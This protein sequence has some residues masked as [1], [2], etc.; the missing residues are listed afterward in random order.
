MAAALATALTAALAVTLGVSAEAGVTPASAASRSATGPSRS[1]T[2]PRN[3]FS[4]TG[5]A[6]SDVS[7]TVQAGA[8]GT[9]EGAADLMLTL[10]PGALHDGV[11]M[12]A[13]PRDPCLTVC[14]QPGFICLAD[15]AFTAPVPPARCAG[16]G[17]ERLAMKGPAGDID[18]VGSFGGLSRG[19]VA[20]LRHGKLFVQFGVEVQQC[21][22]NGCSGATPG[23]AGWRCGSAPGCS[24]YFGDVEMSL[25]PP[26]GDTAR[27][28]A[29]APSRRDARLVQALLTRAGLGNLALER[30]RC[31]VVKV[32]GASPGLGDADLSIFHRTGPGCRPS[33]FGAVYLVRHDRVLLTS[34]VCHCH[35]QSALDDAYAARYAGRRRAYFHLGRSGTLLPGGLAG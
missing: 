20:S 24:G 26:L 1:A 32:A 33:G 30:S 27:L 31:A 2:R 35:R 6:T 25:P 12:T 15:R 11:N 3:G 17:F 23:Y 7:C 8:D 13:Y 18:A 29:L 4:C 9:G 19:F 14:F 28:P 10:S 34:A 5:I 22:A 21:S 16:H